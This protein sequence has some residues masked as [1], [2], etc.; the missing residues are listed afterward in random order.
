[1]EFT[2]DYE[3]EVADEQE[4]TTE[5]NRSDWK[6]KGPEHVSCTQAYV[7]TAL[8]EARMREK[9][10][11]L[12][13]QFSFRPEFV[14]SGRRRKNADRETVYRKKQE[15]RER[16]KEKAAAEAPPPDT[17]TW[18]RRKVPK[19]VQQIIDVLFH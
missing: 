10:N 17:K 5:E 16:E 19:R 14:A 2:Y 12:D 13:R 7:Y 9:R 15:R 18:R 8:H 11:E 4:D 6:P 1:M 3:E